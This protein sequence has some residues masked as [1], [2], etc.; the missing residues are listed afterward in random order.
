MRNLLAI[1]GIAMCELIAPQGTLYG[2]AGAAFEVS[3][4]TAPRNTFGTARPLRT[5]ERIAFQAALVPEIVAFA[6]GF[7]LDRVEQRPQ[8]MY[9][10]RYNVAVTTTAPV[11]LP[12]QKLMLQKLLEDRFGLV[13]RRLS[14]ESWVYY[15]VPGPKVT[16]TAAQEGDTA[17]DTPKFSSKPKPDHQPGGIVVATHVSMSDLADW[18][19]PR[20][21]LPVVDK[22]GIT[23]FFD[24]DIPGL[25][26]R[27]SADGTI[28]SVENAL[29]L[30]FEV[31]RGTAETLIID[32]SEKP[33][34]N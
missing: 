17:A 30:N 22:T 8:W 12:E 20:L 27:S 15:L 31:H 4:A 32:H 19:Y 2:Q 3:P 33:S 1:I 29:G 23:G 10:H 26:L 9:D 13:I 14:Y 5:P 34:F 16:L 24:F 28:Q 11:D 18:L 7:P 21:K 25:A 6:Y